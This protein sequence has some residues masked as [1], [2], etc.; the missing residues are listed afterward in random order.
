[1]KFEN[2]KKSRKERNLKQKDIATILNVD[3]STYSGWETGKDTIPLRKLFD[4]SN[5]YN[6]SIDY[7]TGLSKKNDYIYTSD[8]IDLKSVGENLKKLR[9]NN[10]LKQKDLFNMLNVTSSSYSLYENGKILIQTSF[11]YQIAKKYKISIDSI[12]KKQ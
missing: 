11:I 6:L 3:R 5:F 8:F 10:H 1:M 4:L 12:L 2:I 7:L 9:I